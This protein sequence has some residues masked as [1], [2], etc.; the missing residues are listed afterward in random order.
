LVHHS[1]SAEDCRHYNESLKMVSM[2]D[3]LQ[4]RLQTLLSQLYFFAA[5]SLV[6]VSIAVSASAARPAQQVKPRAKANELD[7]ANWLALI[8]K[9]RGDHARFEDDLAIE[10]YSRIIQVI[11]LE[12][13]QRTKYAIAFLGRA[14]SLESQ[15]QYTKA[16]Q[17]VRTFVASQPYA[18]WSSPTV[19]RVLAEAADYKDA[20]CQASRYVLSTS[21]HA[22]PYAHLAICSAFLHDYKACTANLA[23]AIKFNFGQHDLDWSR[24]PFCSETTFKVLRQKCDEELKRKPREAG[25]WF[26]VALMDSLLGRFQ[27]ATSEFT[28]SLKLDPAMW[29]SLTARANCYLSTGDHKAALSDLNL[30]LALNPVDP[31]T[32][33]TLERFYCL[34]ADFDQIFADLDRRI[35]KNPGNSSLWIAKARAYERL[36]DSDKAAQCYGRA[37]A[38]DP[39][40]AEAF[41]SRGRL[42]QTLL[43]HNDAIA[44][45]SAAIKLEPTDPHSYRDR[46]S[47]YFALHRDKETIADLSQVINL[48]QDPYAYAARAECYSRQS[49]PDLAARDRQVVSQ[50]QPY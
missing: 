23:Q 16:A 22:S 36:G 8:R 19:S 13:E 28:Q 44:D 45:F 17:D 26:T 7:R 29:Q 27:P 2:S 3:H 9:A 34:S 18:R 24:G 15:G 38:S 11:P 21:T 32:Y 4:S 48:T 33:A 41:S 12:G 47:C 10:S 43:Q 14:E 35:G 39:R 20:V 25:V 50:S 6:A 1:S 40:C 42:C 49:K 31:G 46:A 5:A 37:I 30:A